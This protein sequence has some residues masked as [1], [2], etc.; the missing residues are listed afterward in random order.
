MKNEFLPT[1]ISRQTHMQISDLMAD[2]TSIFCPLWLTD[3]RSILLNDTR[4][5][6]E[7]S[8]QKRYIYYCTHILF[9]FR[10]LGFYFGQILSLFF[11]N[12]ADPRGIT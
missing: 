10:D 5:R 9:P 12:P 3:S 1:Y 6:S 7:P 2:I 11:F 8:S 4:P